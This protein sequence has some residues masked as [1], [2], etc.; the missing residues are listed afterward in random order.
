MSSAIQINYVFWWAKYLFV[1]LINE[2][3]EKEVTFFEYK[4]QINFTELQKINIL[5]N[6]NKLIKQ[7]KLFIRL[8]NIAFLTVLRNVI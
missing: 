2:N 4:S 1:I 5:I 8:K 6:R 7:L 3:V